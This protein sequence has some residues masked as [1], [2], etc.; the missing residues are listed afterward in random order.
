ME[1]SPIDTTE[2]ANPSCK[3]ARQ[4]PVLECVDPATIHCE[5]C[6]LSFCESLHGAHRS[7]SCQALK[8]GYSFKGDW[9]APSQLETICS[10]PSSTSVSN[11]T[12]PVAPTE[13]Q[14]V[15]MSVGTVQLQSLSQS[16]EIDTPPGEASVESSLQLPLFTSIEASTTT[17]S[18]KTTAEH[19]ALTQLTDCGKRKWDK[20]I[21]EDNN[22]VYKTAAELTKVAHV[23]TQLRSIL[24]TTSGARLKEVV[25]LHLNYE[26]YDIIFL[27][28]LS[29]EFNVDISHALSCTRPKRAQVLGE[30]IKL[31]ASK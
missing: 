13:Q 10:V 7:H 12:P 24:E 19:D 3:N 22:D 14:I 4:C 16:L 2:T 17:L 21:N 26:T 5:E 30:F 29:R 27:Q 11:L 25:Y 9:V 23:A 6:N 20:I 15:T 28:N 18:L 31:I 1:N 8:A